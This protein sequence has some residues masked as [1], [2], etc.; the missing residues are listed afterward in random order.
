[1]PVCKER[2]AKHYCT[3]ELEKNEN[4]HDCVMIQVWFLYLTKNNLTSNTVLQLDD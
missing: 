3:E 2:K 1:M 4:Y